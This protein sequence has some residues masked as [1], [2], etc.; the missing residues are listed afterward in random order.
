MIVLLDTSAATSKLTLVDGNKEFYDEW[1]AERTLADKLLGYIQA[2]LAKRQATWQDIS[3]IGVYKGPGSFTGLRIGLTVC[4]TIADDLAIPIVG[5]SGED[6]QKVALAKL[7]EGKDE[8]LILP[9][10]GRD[11]NITLPRK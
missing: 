1:L 4:N 10:Y 5:A 7:N 6:W 11:P 9:A 3:G 2:Q 8:K